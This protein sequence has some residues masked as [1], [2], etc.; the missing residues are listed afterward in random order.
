MTLNEKRDR[1][2]LELASW[3]KGYKYRWD[4]CKSPDARGETSGTGTEELA[5]QASKGDY[6]SVYVS[7]A[8]TDSLRGQTSFYIRPLSGEERSVLETIKAL[9]KEGKDPDQ[10]KTYAFERALYD[11]GQDE[12]NIVYNEAYAQV[13]IESACDWANVPPPDIVKVS[14]RLK[15]AG[16][17]KHGSDPQ[18]DWRIVVRPR[19]EL[20]TWLHETA[21]YILDAQGLDCHHTAKFRKLALDLYHH[22]DESFAGNPIGAMEI[23]KLV[24][25]DI[26]WRYFAHAYKPER[27]ITTYNRSYAL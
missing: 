22:F 6:V 1:I 17:Y 15:K 23:A 7:A 24:G 5:R 21:H 19:E 26:D 4:I 9:R 2:R 27:P 20:R 11:W 12:S 8:A 13:V 16:M 25:V 18:P 10:H 14:E 3:G